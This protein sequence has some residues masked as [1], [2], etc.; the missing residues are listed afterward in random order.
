MSEI[1]SNEE[2]VS[3]KQVARMLGIDPSTVYRWCR[4]GKVP[5]CQTPGGQYRI[6]KE[7][8]DQILKPVVP[9][10]AVILPADRHQA[11]REFLRSRGMDV[12]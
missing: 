8:A 5:A 4:S 6:K 7:D 1:Q 2:W 10:A 12:G 11:A 3:A 9:E